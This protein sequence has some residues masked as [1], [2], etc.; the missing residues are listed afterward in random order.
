[1]PK[2]IRLFLPLAV[3][4][5]TI[6]A[7]VEAK[8]QLRLSER[9]SSAR[10]VYLDDEGG[11]T[12][13]GEKARAQLEKWGRF[14]IVSDRAKADLILRLTADPYTDAN[15]TIDKNGDIREEKLKFGQVRPVRYAYLTLLDPATGATLWTGEH[16]WGGLVTGFNSVGE[17]LVKKLEKEASR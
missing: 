6:L 4:V 8:N 9:I 2:S 3:V 11:A 17:R 10:S 5:L 12:A 14:Q 7:T 16:Q 15:I 13:V 1:M